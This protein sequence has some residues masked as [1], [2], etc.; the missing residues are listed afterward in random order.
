VR[1]GVLDRAAQRRVAEPIRRRAAPACAAPCRWTGAARSCRWPWRHPR[2]PAPCRTSAGW[3][4]A[5]SRS[6]PSRIWA[7][8]Q[9]SST[10]AML[11][12]R[13]R[14]GAQ[15]GRAGTRLLVG[16]PEPGPHHAAP[17][18]HG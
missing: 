11:T 12:R 8:L 15:R 18:L 4:C 10:L 16:R 7:Q 5:P 13:R 17:L 6:H 3:S 14:S 2:G 1:G 9:G